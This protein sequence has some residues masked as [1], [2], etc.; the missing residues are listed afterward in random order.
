MSASGLCAD[1]RQTKAPV[2]RRWTPA[3]SVAG[4]LVRRMTSALSPPKP[5]ELIAGHRRSSTL[6]PWFKPRR[7]P[8]TQGLE[9]ESPDWASGNG[10]SPES[11]DDIRSRP[12]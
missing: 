5:N 8:Q 12:P 2:I 6:G 1:K 7:H 3:G 10:G 9:R 4:S 11:A